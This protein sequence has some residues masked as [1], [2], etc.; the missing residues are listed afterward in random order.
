MDF[1]NKPRK[2]LF[3]EHYVLKCCQCDFRHHIPKD[4]SLPNID[5]SVD[6]DEI[7][8]SCLFGGVFTVTLKLKDFFTI[9]TMPNKNEVLHLSIQDN[10]QVLHPHLLSHIDPLY[11]IVQQRPNLTTH[12]YSRK[13]VGSSYVRYTKKG[14]KMVGRINVKQAEIPGETW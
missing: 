11:L 12:E 5:F 7:K 8:L 6:L 4:S 14:H 2:A 10:L 1:F 13:P 9:E 3:Q